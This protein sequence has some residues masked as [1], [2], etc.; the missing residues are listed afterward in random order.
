[1]GVGSFSHWAPGLDFI[2]DPLKFADFANS[3]IGLANFIRFLCAGRGL[4][5]IHKFTPSMIPTA[6]TDNVIITTDLVI[7]RITIGL[8]HATKTIK[9]AYRHC[10]TA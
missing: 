10:L 8:Q 5:R 4:A 2:F 3:H 6:Y 1:V 7:S 9:Q